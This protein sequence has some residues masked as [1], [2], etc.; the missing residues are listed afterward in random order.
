MNIDK[1]IRESIQ[2]NEQ[3][4]RELLMQENQ[5]RTEEL[6]KESGIGEKFKT[7][8]FKNTKTNKNNIVAVKKAMGFTEEFPKVREG[9]LIVGPVGT[10]KTH[11]AASIANKLIRN[12]YTVAFG[13]IT[14]IIILIKSTYGKESEL[15]E[16]EVIRTLTEEVDLLIIDDLGKEYATENTI[17][18]LYHIVNKLS[19]N[20]KPVIITTNLTSEELRKRYKDKG[21]AIVSRIT[22][23]TEPVILTGEDWRLKI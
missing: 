20:N 14:D 4:A 15:T 7:R 17:T 8:T 10:G 22:E 23:M 3:E 16:L 1:F 6:F 9:L 12:L 5:K 2:R 13:N 21:I 18:L 19:E 11:L